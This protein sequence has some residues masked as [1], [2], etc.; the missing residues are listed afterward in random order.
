MTTR[1]RIIISA[2]DVFAAKGKH[3]TRMEEVA[4]EAKINKAMLYYYF[5]TKDNLY[6]EVLKLIFKRLHSEIVEHLVNTRKKTSNH[7]DV[8][9]EVVRTH[10]QMFSRNL[11]HTKIMLEAIANEPDRY[12]QVMGT[13][14]SEEDARCHRMDFIDFIKDGTK[15]GIFRKVDPVHFMI[16][17]MGMTMMYFVARPITRTLCALDEKSEKKFL[18]ARVDSIIDLLL[19]GLVK[20]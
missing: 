13:I 15:K 18:E 16:S 20:K 19:Y 11:D 9:K 1:D 8:I 12:A 3:G 5:S 17:M 10:M 6:G 14:Y 4:K 7:I 2:I